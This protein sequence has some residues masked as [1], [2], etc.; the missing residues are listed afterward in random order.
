MPLVRSRFTV[1]LLAGTLVLPPAIRAQG[2]PPVTPAFDF[3]GVLYA[4]FQRRTDDAAKAANGGKASSK[5]DLERAYLTF[6]MPAGERA[7]IRVT[8]DVFNTADQTTTSFY[9][10]WAVRI[11]YAYLQWNFANDINGSKGFS[12]LAR[13]GV[14]HTVV[15][16]QIE[17]YNPRYLAQTDLERNGFFSSAD[18][19]AALLVSLPKKWGEVY[20]TITNG[21]G[22]TVA[23][24]D[25][26]KDFAGRLTVTPFAS[27][28][29]LGAWSKAL[30]VS[31]WIYAGKTASKFQNG[32]TG[33]VGTVPEGLKRN[34]AGVFVGAKDPRLTVGIDYGQRTETTEGGDNTVASPRTTTEVTGKVKS[35]FAI[36]KP[37]ALAG[38]KSSLARLGL[39]ARFDDFKPNDSA[40]A[41][42]QFTIFGL[43]Y[44]PTSKVTFSLD[45]QQLK[46]KD[47]SATPEAK[48]LF[49]HM[50]ALF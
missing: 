9:R 6:R 43:Y 45:A 33:Q 8:T 42:N 50:Q 39:I 22:Y 15:V 14:L 26:Y 46:P 1:L 23:E 34:R 49:V 16:D 24:N 4:N 28:N 10:G 37:F 3:S 47:G 2:T 48:T 31:P 17:Q 25:R 12:A 40:D 27:G 35:A 30:I 19:G 29:A 18:V 32:G 38:T 11:K 13:F 36:V 41:H 5:F 21:P 44:E 7:S 20:G